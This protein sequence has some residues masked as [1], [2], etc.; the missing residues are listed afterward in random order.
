[1]LDVP[2][3]EPGMLTDCAGTYVGPPPPDVP[4]PPITAGVEASDL[5]LHA[6]RAGLSPR[7]SRPEVEATLRLGARIAKSGL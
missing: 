6:A 3:F 5:L 7:A 4:L 2:A 1:M